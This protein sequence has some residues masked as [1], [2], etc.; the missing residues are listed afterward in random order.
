MSMLSVT[1]LG[2]VKIARS[3]LDGSRAGT[4]VSC[5]PVLLDDLNAAVRLCCS[6]GDPADGGRDDGWVLDALREGYGQATAGWR[7]HFDATAAASGSCSAQFWAML[8]GTVQGLVHGAPSALVQ[9]AVRSLLE[10]GDVVSSDLVLPQR[11]PPQC[12]TLQ[13][14]KVKRP[15]CHRAHGKIKAEPS[16]WVSAGPLVVELIAD[17]S[18][19]VG[20]VVL[21]VS[22]A[23]SD[24]LDEEQS[25]LWLVQAGAR[26]L[27]RRLASPPIE[28]ALVEA[29]VRV[30]QRL[31]PA[32]AEPSPEPF[33]GTVPSAV[34]SFL[35][36]R[37]RLRSS[38][39]P[40]R[41]SATCNAVARSGSARP[42]VGVVR[43]QCC[44]RAQRWAPPRSCS[45][46]SPEAAGRVQAAQSAGLLHSMFSV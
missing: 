37:V 17:V 41:Q 45:P 33:C 19:R 2:V 7:G 14:Q 8:Q 36:R 24:P 42:S 28:L 3:W 11:G 10:A 43:A 31:P 20:D 26:S 39:G 25:L 34:V 18:P 23:L 6:C 1:Q 35:S 30:F 22:D 44:C 46:P 40:Q 29:A 21:A 32:A 16:T 13:L 15:A 38:P 12:C 4:Q 27:S 5:P 9:S